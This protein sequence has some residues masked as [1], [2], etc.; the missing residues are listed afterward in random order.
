MRSR[1][2]LLVP[3]LAFLLLPSMVIAQDNGATPCESD[4]GS[5]GYTCPNLSGPGGIGQVNSAGDAHGRIGIA[6]RLLEERQDEGEGEGASADLG[7]GFG[8]FVHGRLGFGE[9]DRTAR[10]NESESDRYGVVLGGDWRSGAVVLGLAFDYTRGDTDF[11]GPIGVLTNARVGSVE[12]DEFGLQAFGLFEPAPQLSLSGLARI[13]YNNYDT[14]R[15]IN[16]GSVSGSTDGTVFGA[17]AGANYDLPVGAGV[18]LGLS[19]LLDFQRTRID[20]YNESPLPGL[21]LGERVRFASDRITTLTSHIGARVSRAYSTES[22]VLVPYLGARWLHEFDDDSRTIRST[23][24][25]GGGNELA[26][27]DIRTNAPDRDHFAIDLGL[28]A[29]FAG[30]WS[31]FAAYDV[32]LGHSFRKEHNI[33]IGLRREF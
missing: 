33:A 19:G 32:L 22:A 21:A 23:V 7:R 24:V 11:K 8:V 29:V 14:S 2:S 18:T 16:G 5:C 3:A 30:G 9:Q 12:S 26:F 28:S 13:G 27:T 31:A 20:G 17:A 10:E 15:R 1:S 25:D 6:R 4:Q